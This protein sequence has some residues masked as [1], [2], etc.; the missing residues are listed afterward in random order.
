MYLRERIRISVAYSVL[1]AAFSNQ[2]DANS[3]GWIM[4]ITGAIMALV[5]AIDAT[6]VGMLATLNIYLPIIVCISCLGLA[7]FLMS[8]T[9]LG[10]MRSLEVV[11]II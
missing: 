6:I 1:I 2:V 7:A 4:G 5:W 8:R 11:G 10:A 9:H 3:Q